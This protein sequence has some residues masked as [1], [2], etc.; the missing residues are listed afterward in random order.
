MKEK[1]KSYEFWV[2]VVSAVMVVLQS[3]SIKFNAPY[4]Q[5]AVL[6][7]LGALALTGML[8]KSEKQ[9][10]TQEGVDGDEVNSKDGENKDAAL[11]SDDN[12]SG[13]GGDNDK[14]ER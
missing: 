5:E 6:G 12:T 4:I 13:I 10:P 14:D 9:L 1:I 7:I 2:S 8:K 3:I 11:N